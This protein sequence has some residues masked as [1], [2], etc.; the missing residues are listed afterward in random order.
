LALGGASWARYVSVQSQPFVCRSLP[1]MVMT[2]WPPSATRSPLTP[3]RT[4]PP[5]GLATRASSVDFPRRLAQSGPS[6]QCAEPHTGSSAMP[7]QGANPR[8][9]KSY[10][11]ASGRSSPSAALGSGTAGGHPAHVRESTR[12]SSTLPGRLISLSDVG[13]LA[14]R[15]N[16]SGVTSTIRSPPPGPPRPPP[17]ERRPPWRAQVTRSLPASGAGHHSSHQ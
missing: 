12:H 5:R 4:S 3:T 10:A 16:A 7:T 15:P 1:I 17:S 14:R 2:A 9:E 8:D 6:A 13:Y 11:A